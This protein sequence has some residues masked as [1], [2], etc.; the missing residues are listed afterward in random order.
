MPFDADSTARIRPEL[1]EAPKPSAYLVVMRGPGIG[2]RVGMSEGDELYIGRSSNA[3]LRLMDDGISRMHCRVR[4]T[5]GWLEIEDLGSRNGT[6]HNDRPVLACKLR[7]GDRIQLGAETV[8]KFVEMDELDDMFHDHLIESATRDAL[9]LAFNRQYF[10]ERL[11][12]EVKFSIRHGAA[13]SLLFLDLDHFKPINDRYGH[14]AGDHVLRE[15]GRIAAAMVRGEDTFARY[16][17]EEFAIIARGTTARGAFAFAERIRDATNAMRTRYEGR[18]IPI[19]VS[20]GVASTPPLVIRTSTE[21]IHAADLAL[22]RAKAGGRNRTERSDQ[23][24]SRRH[25][26]RATAAI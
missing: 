19:S 26:A 22:Y 18:Q 20:I 17:G 24:S 11:D 13:L 16:G 7:V 1:L 5:G 8:I 3:D 10:L 4:L 14:L 9:T 6:L 25:A 12:A 21:L 15:F 2:E 23:H